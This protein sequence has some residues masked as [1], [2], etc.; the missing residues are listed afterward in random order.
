MLF[1]YNSKCSATRNFNCYAKIFC[2]VLRNQIKN[3]SKKYIIETHSEYLLNKIRLGIVKGEIDEN[4][5]K[6]YFIDNQGKEAVTYKIYFNKQG[7]ILNAP[8][9]FFKTYMMDVMEIA[10][11]AAN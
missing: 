8:D 2:H 9:N 4:D 6:T 7:Q 3:S 1:F 10:I 11:N 5:V